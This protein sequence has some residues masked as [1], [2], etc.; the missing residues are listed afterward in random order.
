MMRSGRLAVSTLLTLALLGCGT[1]EP[2]E[3]TTSERGGRTG[4]AA[5][6][7]T[8]A[9]RA[10]AVYVALLTSFVTDGGQQRQPEAITIGVRAEYG[11]GWVRP[12]SP[13]NEPIVI[14]AATRDSVTAQFQDVVDVR[15]ADD[16]GLPPPGEWSVTLSP[17]PDSGERLEI[18]VSAFAG[19]DNGWLQTYVLE[20]DGDGWVVTGTTAPAGIT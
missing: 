15:W 14:V 9:E 13:P 18:S 8:T 12:T 4:A 19:V 17:V 1:V 11:G 5:T 2:A 20:D 16:P 6:N 7:P 10:A 3:L